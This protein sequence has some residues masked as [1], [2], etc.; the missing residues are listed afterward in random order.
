MKN[1]NT[2]KVGLAQIAPVWLD[3]LKTIEKIKSA[4]IDAV[5]QQCELVVF[6]EGLLPGYPFWLSLTNGAEFNSKVQK[7]IHV[8]YLRNAIQIELGE[9]NEICTVA[10]E[11]KTAI[12]LGIIE[13]PKN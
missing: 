7:E 9:L 4:I 3:K 13:R 5:A 12:Y 6:G 2:L 11:N 10:R 8:H 1:S